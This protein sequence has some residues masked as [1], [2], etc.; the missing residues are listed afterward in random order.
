MLRNGLLEGPA[1]QAALYRFIECAASESDGCRPNRR[2]KNLERTKGDLQARVDPADQAACR[3]A[4]F[5]KAPGADRMW[6]HDLKAL[7]EDNAAI[8]R[9]DGERRDVVSP[10]ATVQACK[11]DI[12]VGEP[13][14]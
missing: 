13:A 14:V 11:D 10:L 7:L 4:T 8:V 1:G 12:E 3:N 6:R 2:P 5:L 9:L